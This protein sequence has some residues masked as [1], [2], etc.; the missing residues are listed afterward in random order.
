MYIIIICLICNCFAQDY[1]PCKD[2]RFLFLSKIELDDMSDRQYN[3][4]IKKEE[5]CSKYKTRKSINR[6]KSKNIKKNKKYMESAKNNSY[7]AGVYSSLPLFRLN[8]VA[9]YEQV[10]I[11][12]F[13]LETPISFGVGR[14]N[15]YLKFELR[16]Y[17]F[18]KN[19]LDNQEFGGNAILVGFS[20]PVKFFKAKSNWFHPEFSLLTGKFHFSKGLLI[21]FN[22]PQQFSSDSPIKIKY[23]LM[24]NIVQSGANNGT[25][26]CD[27]SFNLGYSFKNLIKE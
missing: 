10:S 24:V 19:N 8:M 13:K 20:L 15:A 1:N 5:E 25:G 22:L 27:F 14:S 2:K 11:N 18:S 23:S 16:N 17:S 21:G 6:I 12:G 26:W 9:G 7:T 3:Y 4:Y